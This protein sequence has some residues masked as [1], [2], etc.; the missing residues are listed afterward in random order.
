MY[1][2]VKTNNKNNITILPIYR[3]AYYLCKYL[4]PWWIVLKANQENIK[5]CE[6]YTIIVKNLIILKINYYY[7][8][9]CNKRQKAY[10]GLKK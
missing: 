8:K 10:L 9:F 2:C 6:C 1:I 5:N 3:Y 4:F 7:S